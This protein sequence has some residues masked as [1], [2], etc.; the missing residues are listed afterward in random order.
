MKYS[1]KIVFSSTL[2]LIISISITSIFQYENIEKN[3]QKQIDV[4]VNN[5]LNSIELQVMA[6]FKEKKMFAQFITNQINQS[7]TIE[8]LT[9]VSGDPGVIASFDFVGGAFDSD[10]VPIS[11][12]HWNTAPE[13]DARKRP[14][15]K[16][17]KSAKT[18]VTTEPYLDAST[19]EMIISFSS[20]ISKNNSFLGSVFFDVSLKDLA[21]LVNAVDIYGAGNVFV[22]TKQGVIIAHHN[23]NYNGQLVNQLY[24]S[25]D[26]SERNDSSIIIDN[27]EHLVSIRPMDG[28]DYIL[29]SDVNNSLAY[30]SIGNIKYITFISV[31]LAAISSGIILYILINKLLFPLTRLGVSLSSIASGSGDLTRKISETGDSEFVA[32]ARS[33]N[34][35]VEELR[36]MIEKL[37]QT[38]REL[39]QISKQTTFSSEKTK[40]VM[41]S[42]ES[43]IAQLAT[44]IHEM[45]NVS[46]QVATNTLTVARSM[47]SA[48]ESVLQGDLVVDNAVQAISS[49]A[50]AIGN[51]SNNV[52]RLETSTSK[53]NTVIHVINE[54]A[55]QTNLLALNAA[56]E[57]A[58]AGEHGR[59]FAVVSEEVRTLAQRTQDSTFEIKSLINDLHR[60]T[61]DVVEHMVLSRNIADGS[62]KEIE[63]VKQSLLNIKNEIN[64]LVDM[65]NQ[66]AAASE[67]QNLVAKEIDLKSSNIHMLSMDVKNYNVQTHECIAHQVRLIEEQITILNRFIV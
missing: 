61:D 1:N 64:N 6:F 65:N 56:I 14:W 19:N 60:N 53:I 16:L 29:I 28:I 62:V 51:T 57:A 13:W 3:M 12:N 50:K 49:L 18:L 39:G 11:G 15:Y 54:I 23:K 67:E 8:T 55:E 36:M 40:L 32:L 9:S 52:D 24:P 33:F 31:F 10:G 27:V 35:F 37:S 47:E 4:G 45:S 38:G 2:I 17:A 48:N 21:E 25:L 44:A 5:I 58:R 26:Y 42:Q 7:P 34:T 20:P 41:D 63:K 46:S 59:G 30:H 66:I 43:E 22:A